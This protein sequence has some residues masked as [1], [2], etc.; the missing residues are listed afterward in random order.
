MSGTGY[1]WYFFA[2]LGYFDSFVGSCYSYL[3][4]DNAFYNESYVQVNF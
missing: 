3:K 1:R 4:A 2:F